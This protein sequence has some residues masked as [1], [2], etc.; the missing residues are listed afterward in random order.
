[1]TTTTNTNRRKKASDVRLTA[2]RDAELVRQLARYAETN[3]L[4]TTTGAARAILTQF[5]KK[6]KP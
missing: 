5:F 4:S 1:M 3:G 6:G 2:E